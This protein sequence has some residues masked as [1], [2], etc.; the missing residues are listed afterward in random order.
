MLNFSLFQHIII[1]FVHFQVNNILDISFNE[2]IQ[3]PQVEKQFLNIRL[4]ESEWT[5]RRTKQK[6]PRCRTGALIK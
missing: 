4:E 3:I 2:M 5:F 1:Y 6:G